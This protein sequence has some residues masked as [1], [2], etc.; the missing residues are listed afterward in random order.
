MQE[1][2]SILVSTFLLLLFFLLSVYFILNEIDGTVI[3]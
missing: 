3:D 1:R 2:F